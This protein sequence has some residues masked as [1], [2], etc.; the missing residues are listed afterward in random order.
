MHT[1]KR[2]IEKKPTK[3]NKQCCEEIM[4]DN[5]RPKEGV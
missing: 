1:I 2:P 5:C 4:A 3:A